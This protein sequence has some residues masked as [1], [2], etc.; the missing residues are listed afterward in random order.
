MDL[1]H[2]ALVISG[3]KEEEWKEEGNHHIHEE[4]K[5]GSFSRSFAMPPDVTTQVLLRILLVV[6]WGGPPHFVVSGLPP[7][8]SPPP[9]SRGWLG[10][11]CFGCVCV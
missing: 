2:G 1:K 6:G 4:R 8:G 10:C 3:K 11:V 7:V 5:W 9:S